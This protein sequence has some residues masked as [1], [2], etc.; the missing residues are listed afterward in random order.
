MN[1]AKF[2]NTQKAKAAWQ[3]DIPDW[4]II[5][6]EA[7]DRETQAAVSRKVG[8][9]ASAVSQVLSNTYQNGDIGRF[10]QAVRGALMAE[11]VHCPVLGEL[12][13]NTCISWQRKPFST[14]NSHNVRMYGACRNGCK[15]SHLKEGT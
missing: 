13:R 1:A 11:T 6:A 8:Y 9:S 5:L 3:N 2:T 15:H 10:E 7:C 14:A 4:V 12:P